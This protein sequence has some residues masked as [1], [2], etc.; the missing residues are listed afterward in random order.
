MS[1]RQK[2]KNTKLSINLGPATTGLSDGIVLIAG[3]VEGGYSCKTKSVPGTRTLPTGDGCGG[4]CEIVSPTPRL[5]YTTSP[6][7]S[8]YTPKHRIFVEPVG[9]N[10]DELRQVKFD[11][12]LDYQCHLKVR[13]EFKVSY[14]KPR[15]KTI[16]FGNVLDMDLKSRSQVKVKFVKTPHFP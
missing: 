7:V 16:S 15:P 9:I 2:L 4:H 5:S 1:S 6:G 14:F 10:M 8:F 12:Y 11:I 3:G 13:A